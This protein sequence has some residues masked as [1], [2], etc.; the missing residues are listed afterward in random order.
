MIAST[1][2]F[3][4]DLGIGSSTTLTNVRISIYVI[5][6]TVIFEANVRIFYHKYENFDYKYENL[7]AS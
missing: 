7:V 1:K 3:L 2:I 4:D 6:S 5:G